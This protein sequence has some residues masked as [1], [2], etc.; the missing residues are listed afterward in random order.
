MN[1][2]CATL[3]F[4]LLWA[5]WHLPLFF[6]KGY[7]HNEI[8]RMNFIYGINFMVAIV[9]MA[10]IISWLCKL[11]RGSI[12]VAIVFHFFINICQEAFQITQDTKCIETLVLLMIAAV[13]VLLDRKLFFEKKEA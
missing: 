2:F 6:V 12:P 3:L 9:P 7:Y 4:A 13:I 8:I 1:Y 5:G 11:N 10:F